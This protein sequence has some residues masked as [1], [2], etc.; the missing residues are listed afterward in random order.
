MSEMAILELRLA[1]YRVSEGAISR[2]G[3]RSGLS[4]GAM[5]RVH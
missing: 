1:T 2:I 3:G 4:E 5:S